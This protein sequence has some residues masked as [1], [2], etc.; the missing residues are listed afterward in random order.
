MTLRWIP[1]LGAWPSAPPPARRPALPRGAPLTKPPPQHAPHYPCPQGTEWD[2]TECVPTIHRSLGLTLPQAANEVHAKGI[3]AAWG[4]S[5]GVA[6]PISDYGSTDVLVAGWSERDGVM[7]HAFATWWTGSPKLNPDADIADANGV[8][9]ADLTPNHLAALDA[10]AAAQGLKL[11][12]A[13]AIDAAASRAILVIWGKTDG[14]KQSGVLADYGPGDVTPSWTFRDQTML[15]VF[16]L[17]WNGQGRSALPTSGVLDVSS[18]VALKTWAGEEL[19]K[20]PAGWA[21]PGA[22]PSTTPPVATCKS[23]EVWDETNKA[24][25]P[26]PAGVAVTEPPAAKSNAIWWV[27]GGV[28]VVGGLLWYFGRGVGA[29]MGE[30]GAKENPVWSVPSGTKR[31]RRD[32]ILNIATTNAYGAP[33]FKKARG[34]VNLWR[35]EQRISA[36]EE[37]ELLQMLDEWEALKVHENPTGYYVHVRGGNNETYGPYPTLQRAK[38]F[39]RIGATKGKHDRVVLKGGKVVRHY[40]AGTGESLVHENPESFRETGVFEHEG[41]TYEAGGGFYDK[42]HGVLAGYPKRTS[43]G[44]VLTTWNGK[45]ITSL[46]LKS[47]FR[48]GFGRTKMYAWSAQYDGRHFTGRNSGEGM[49]VFLR[50]R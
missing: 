43:D 24:C 26:L 18:S 47:T 45:T 28:A 23:G 2:G 32:K 44:W 3:L 9:V 7:L 15:S 4:K 14:A 49:V 48:G 33:S 19:A 29:A 8:V 40:R 16:Q 20:V 42:E 35:T 11:P 10:W 46:T 5:P 22:Q 1:E 31:E 50:A 12:A 38:T 13:Q 34:I 41:K 25:Q 17:W 21:A 30:P 39:A 6:S 37:R 27:L 36:K